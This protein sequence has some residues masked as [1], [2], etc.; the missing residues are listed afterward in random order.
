MTR[1][2][3]EL[4]Q[5]YAGTVNATEDDP[6][7]VPIYEGTVAGLADGRQFDTAKALEEGDG[8]IVADERDHL[9]VTFLQ[10]H[11]PLKSAA[12]PP[13]APVAGL[14]D[15]TVPQL[16][17]RAAAEGHEGYEQL[18]KNELIDLLEG[19]PTTGEEA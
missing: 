2:A 16:K 8:V 4:R 7:G 11:P 13:D 9:L 6:D 1:V 10:E 15:L 17:E 18:R 14:N 19:H 12:V 5:E 3:F